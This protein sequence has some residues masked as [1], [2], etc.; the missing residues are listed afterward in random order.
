MDFMWDS[1]KNLIVNSLSPSDTYMCRTVTIIGS[2]ND[3]SPGRRQVIIWTNAR[4]LL[5]SH[6]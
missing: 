3:L 6:C 5:I 2:D 4:I 1:G